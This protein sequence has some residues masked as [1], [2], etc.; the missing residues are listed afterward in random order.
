[1]SFDLVKTAQNDWLVMITIIQI[2]LEYIPAVLGWPDMIHLTMKLASI[3]VTRAN[4]IT[5]MNWKLKCLFF[6]LIK[7]EFVS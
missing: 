7:L 1:M 4:D 5:T 3:Y 6:D 2:H